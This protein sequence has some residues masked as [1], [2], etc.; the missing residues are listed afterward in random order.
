MRNLPHT[1]AVLLAIFILPPPGL[2]AQTT[3]AETDNATAPE[4]KG[5]EYPWPQAKPLPLSVSTTWESAPEDPHHQVFRI[6]GEGLSIAAGSLGPFIVDDTI[7]VR[8]DWPDSA[9][10][11]DSRSRSGMLCLTHFAKDE[12]LPKVDK[13]AVTGYAK[14][15]TQMTNPEK[16]VNVEIV[17]P[18]S[19]IDRKAVILR[20]KPI[21]ITWRKTDRNTGA[22]FQR[23]DYFLELEDGSLLVVSVMATPG[24]EP[25]T[26]AAA[27]EM[28]RFAYI[29]DKAPGS[30]K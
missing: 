8:A 19:E 3:Q 21:F 12:F 9:V 18:P 1:I 29:E 7:P 5:A 16:G 20:L 15:L 23:T 17:T 4:A 6:K 25:G 26:R 2:T 22:D 30:A 24:E 27:Y 13:N 14:S 10:L 11:Y 28:L